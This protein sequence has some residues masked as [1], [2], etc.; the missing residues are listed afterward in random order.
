MKLYV[1]GVHGIHSPEGDNSMAQFMPMVR[2]NLPGAAQVELFSYG[3]MGFWAARWDNAGV[4]KKLAKAVANV[5]QEQDAFVALVT[6]SNGA[7]ITYRAVKDYAADIDMVVNINPALD[8]WKTPN[9]DWVE[10][11]HSSQDRWVDLSQ[12]LPFH[13]W[14]DQ[15]KV[16]YRGKLKNTINHDASSYSPPMGYGGHCDAFSA[17]RRHWWANFVAQRIQQ[18][19]ELGLKGA[20]F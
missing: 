12:W 13:D 10:T 18:Q 14:G 17:V 8:R 1:L 7:A 5:R 4:A 3:F 2:Q 19:F 6:H 9:V 20:A 16:G 11:I 15:G